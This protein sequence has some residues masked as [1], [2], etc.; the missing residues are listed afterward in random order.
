MSEVILKFRIQTID[1]MRMPFL[2]DFESE[3][4]FW[5]AVDIWNN[6]FQK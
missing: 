6:Y 4:D 2:V 1:G 5:E 3:E